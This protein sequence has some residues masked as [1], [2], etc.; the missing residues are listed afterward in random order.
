MCSCSTPRWD[1]QR[2]MRI[3]TGSLRG[4]RAPAELM[5]LYASDDA[6]RGRNDPCTCGRK[7]KHCCG[8]TP[9]A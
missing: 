1:I 3:M 9:A 2:Q 5:Q 4:G 7:W 8:D 6:G